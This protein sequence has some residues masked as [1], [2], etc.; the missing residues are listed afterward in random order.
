MEH[1][2]QTYENALGELESSVDGLSAEQ[3]ES[4]LAR[5][6]K[7]KFDDAKKDSLAKRFIKQVADPMIIMLIAA[8]VISAALGEIADMAIIL[9]V[10]MLNA[11]LGLY[12]ESKA[13]KAIEALQQMSASYSK[14]R[15]SGQ[16]TLVKSEELV[17]GDIVLLEAGDAVPADMR[18]IESVSLKIEEASL[19]VCAR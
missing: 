14:V 12:Q 3:A 5:Y 1:Y 15:R 16:P 2:L 9:I 19:T 10:V 11:V 8:A 7:N 6:G 18:L 17:P 13:E 4:R